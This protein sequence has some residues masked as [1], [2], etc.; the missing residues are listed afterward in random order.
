MSDTDGHRTEDEE[1]QVSDQ[2]EKGKKR[3][4]TEE[5][6]DDARRRAVEKAA[7]LRA[8]RKAE[9]DQ[10]LAESEKVRS[11]K[12]REMEKWWRQEAC[13]AQLS[14]QLASSVSLTAE[15]EDEVDSFCPLLVDSFCQPSPS[16]R[17]AKRCRVAVPPNIG[18]AGPSNVVGGATNTSDGESELSESS[19]EP[20]EKEGTRKRKR[21]GGSKVNVEE[22]KKVAGKLIRVVKDQSYFIHPECQCERCVRRKINCWT[23]KDDSYACLDCKR[24]SIKCSARTGDRPVKR[25]AGNA[26]R[27]RKAKAKEKRAPKS[28]AGEMEGPEVESLRD[29]LF[30]LRCRHSQDRE[31]MRIIAEGLSTAVRDQRMELWLRMTAINRLSVEQEYEEL[32]EKARGGVLGNLELRLSLEVVTRPKKKKVVKAKKTKKSEEDKEENAP[33]GPEE[34]ANLEVIPEDGDDGG[35]L[36]N[37]IN[38]SLGG[39]PMDIDCSPSPEAPKS[40][41][42]EPLEGSLEE[43]KKAINAHNMRKKAQKERDLK[44][45][46][47]KVQQELLEAEAAKEKEEE[48]K[49][50]EKLKELLAVKKEPEEP[51][52]LPPGVPLNIIRLG[53]GTD[54]M[55]V[56]DLVSSDEEDDKPETS[57]ENKDSEDKMDE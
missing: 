24:G 10:L 44:M 30:R 5:V 38:M 13:I 15:E 2:E 57:G 47:L 7:A 52:V 36:A 23:P 28:E 16:S 49:K 14:Q 17:R 50:A 4:P 29:S 22:T 40:P 34:I 11:Q 19:D 43:Q 3:A 33:E 25:A 6:E 9:L 8:V 31:V 56:I 37:A 55:E 39:A 41:K 32:S 1:E 48:A 51:S 18:E 12:E 35:E 20:E 42:E 53:E 46:E 21:A 26:P 27:P 45:A 54:G